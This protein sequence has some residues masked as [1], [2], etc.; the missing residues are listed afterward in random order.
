MPINQISFPQYNVNSQMDFT[1]LAKLGDQWRTQQLESAKRDTLA[2][3]GPDA[4]RNA[5]ILMGSG[6]PDLATMGLNIQHQLRSEGREDVQ[7]AN[8]NR[9]AD[10]ALGIQQAAARRTQ[11]DWLQQEKDRQEAGKLV[12]GMFPGAAPP[13]AQP[14]PAPLPGQ[15]GPPQATPFPAPLP[16]PQAPQQPPQQPQAPVEPPSAFEA[17]P[18]LPAGLQPP[19]VSPPVKAEGDEPSALPSWVQSAQ[20][21]P[22]D[23]SI[24]GRISSNLTSQQPAAA[25]GISR[26]Q[27]GALMQN[28]LTRPLATAF[29]QKQFNPGEWKYEKTDDGRLIATNS[30]D[31]RKTIDV[32]PPT[33]TGAPPGTKEEREIQGYF[34]AGKAL[35]M[36]DEE[37][38]AFAANKGKTPKTDL[39]ANEEKRIST[40]T[41]EARTGARVLTTVNQLKELS[42]T[43]WGFKGA[44]PASLLAATV[45]P[46]GLGGAGATD[47]QD[48]INAAHTNV[49]NVAK[50]I[51]PQRVTNTD[52]Q[53]LKELES[54][55]D[56]P[57]VVRQ[58]LYKR[59]EEMI[60]EKVKDAEDEAEAIRNRTFYKPRK[61]PDA[62]LTSPAPAVTWK[63]VP[64]T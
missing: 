35:N 62:S 36:S 15:G 58:R 1:P 7:L 5:Q 29:L 42:K 56:Q 51:F 33:G 4:A 12:G 20:A 18:R 53:L 21:Q 63:I 25:A 17:T 64:G 45:L 50:S 3:L 10:A 22:P 44:G 60:R 59:T 34:R 26:E 41:D 24:V 28:P 37:A 40:L 54:S 11:E 57:D 8:T 43:A 52:L 13:A 61:A 38:R 23:L 39:S 19:P 46:S 47:T 55:A 30:L 14:F 32:T 48:L 9:R 49:V 16:A 2:Q 27:L 31:P 6:I